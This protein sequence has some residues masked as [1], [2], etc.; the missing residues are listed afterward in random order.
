MR[1][2]LNPD[3]RL[4]GSETRDNELLYKQPNVKLFDDKQ[5]LYVQRRNGLSPRELQVA[6]H[7]CSGFP[8]EDIAKRLRIRTGTVKTHLRNIYRRIHVTNK[9]GMLLKFIE[10]AVDFYGNGEVAGGAA[11]AA[12]RL[13]KQ[14]GNSSDTQYKA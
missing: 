11:F 6:Q 3:K 1:E 7:V 14:D 12:S 10:Q 2:M 13:F 5:W 9:I 8:N 4:A